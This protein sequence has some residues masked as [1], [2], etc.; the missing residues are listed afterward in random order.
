MDGVIRIYKETADNSDPTVEIGFTLS[1]HQHEELCFQLLKV[2]NAFNTKP[3]FVR[4]E[5]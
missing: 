5:D 4:L 1:K 3:D 2:L